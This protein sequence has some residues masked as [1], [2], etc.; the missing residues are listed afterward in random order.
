MFHVFQAIFLL[1][2]LHLTVLNGCMPDKIPNEVKI[3]SDTYVC[4]TL[5]PLIPGNYYYYYYYYYYYVLLDDYKL[6]YS[7]YFYI[8]RFKYDILKTTKC[9]EV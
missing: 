4:M 2:L 7:N 3:D 1:L 9:F 5:S 6:K 8:V